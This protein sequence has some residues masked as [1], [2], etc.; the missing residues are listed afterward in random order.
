MAKYIKKA[1]DA[2]LIAVTKNILTSAQGNIFYYA[3]DGSLTKDELKLLC[4]DVHNDVSIKELPPDSW[5]S[6]PNITI[7]LPS[8]IIINSSSSETIDA[9]DVPNPEIRTVVYRISRTRYAMYSSD[10][11]KEGITVFG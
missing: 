1:E 8:G 10:E 7:S 9:K 5:S 3:A 4:T 6:Y 2:E 11:G